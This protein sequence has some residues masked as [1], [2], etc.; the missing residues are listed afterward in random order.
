MAKAS[1]LLLTFLVE[2]RGRKDGGMLETVNNRWVVDA[3]HVNFWNGFFFMFVCGLHV[4]YLCVLLGY[5][6]SFRVPTDVQFF[7]FSYVYGCI[8]MHDDWY[9]TFQENVC[10]APTELNGQKGHIFLK[11]TV[12]QCGP[13]VCQ[14][15]S[16]SSFLFWLFTPY[17]ILIWMSNRVDWLTVSNKV[18]TVH[19]SINEL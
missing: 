10:S 18:D 16:V 13:S 5:R 4:G 19:N 6:P 1:F 8:R 14:L 2:R 15:V 7:S 3:H 12:L 17:S 11:G 9:S